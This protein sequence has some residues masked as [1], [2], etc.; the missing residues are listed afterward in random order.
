MARSLSSHTGDPWPGADACSGL[1]CRCQVGAVGVGLLADV[2]YAAALTQ[3]QRD[4]MTPD[5]II[6]IMKKR[7]RALPPRQKLHRDTLAEQRASA[8]GQYPGGGDPELHRFAGAGRT[9]PRLGHRRH[10]QRRVAGNI[11][12]DDILGS[13]EFACQL[14]A[15]RSCW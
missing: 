15:P 13:L 5:Q 6:A 2:A 11:A 9:H 4:A 12:N 8:K 14:R 7:Q 10:L 3:T 1:R